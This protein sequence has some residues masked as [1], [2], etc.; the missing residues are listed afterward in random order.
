MK[1]HNLN[2]TKRLWT[3]N[4]PNKYIKQARDVFTEISIDMNLLYFFKMILVLKSS[5]E[6]TASC[7]V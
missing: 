2:D 6:R 4:S 3:G 5:R 7:L 1:P